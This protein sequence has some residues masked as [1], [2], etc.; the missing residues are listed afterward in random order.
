MPILKYVSTRAIA[1][2]A[3]SKVNCLLP[4]HFIEATVAKDMLARF[5]VTRHH[6]K[7]FLERVMASKAAPAKK[8]VEV[9]RINAS[10]CSKPLKLKVFTSLLDHFF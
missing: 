10:A 9:R 2:N 8:F 3:L 6:V 1:W 7:Q 5:N 4:V